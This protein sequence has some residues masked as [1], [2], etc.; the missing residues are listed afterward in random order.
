MSKFK[1]INTGFKAGIVNPMTTTFADDGNT[2]LGQMCTAFYW[3]MTYKAMSQNHIDSVIELIW[4]KDSE[5]NTEMKELAED[6]KFGLAVDI[7]TTYRL[8]TRPATKNTSDIYNWLKQAVEVILGKPTDYPVPDTTIF[9]ITGTDTHTGNYLQILSLI[10]PDFSP[11]KWDLMCKDILE[12]AK[13]RPV[14]GARLVKSRMETVANLLDWCLGNKYNGLKPEYIQDILTNLDS[15]TLAKPPV[16]PDDYTEAIK[17][18]TV[19]PEV[20]EKPS[21][22]PEPSTG[23]ETIQPVPQAPEKKPYLAPDMIEKENPTPTADIPAEPTTP[24]TV[25]PTVQEEPEKKPYVAPTMSERDNPDTGIEQVQPPV[26]PAQE[27]VPEATPIQ[28]QVDDDSEL[29]SLAPPTVEKKPYVAPTMTITEEPKD[30]NDSLTQVD[31]PAQTQETK[32][33]EE[34]KSI[35]TQ[36]NKPNMTKTGKLRPSDRTLAV[37]AKMSINKDQFK[38]AVQEVS[39]S[40]DSDDINAQYLVKFVPGITDEILKDILENRTTKG[41]YRIP[42]TG[43]GGAGIPHT[44]FTG[45]QTYSSSANSHDLGK[46]MM[47]IG[48]TQD[49]SSVMWNEPVIMEMGFPFINFKSP[50]IYTMLKEKDPEKATQAYNKVKKLMKKAGL[51]QPI[52]VLQD[53]RSAKGVPCAINRIS[54]PAE[55]ILNESNNIIQVDVHPRYSKDYSLTV[56]SLPLSKDFIIEMYRILSPATGAKIYMAHLG[57]DEEEYADMI[58]NEGHPPIYIFTP[59]E[60]MRFVKAPAGFIAKLFTSN[61]KPT[62]V[63]AKMGSHM[64]GFVMPFKTT[65]VLFTEI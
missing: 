52:K 32:P 31:T 53:F 29:D 16:L 49:K 22:Q 36:S 21:V 3:Q 12:Y 45:G 62:L 10:D 54:A 41:S 59:K 60:N 63:E 9:S 25:E 58:A 42:D 48:Y 20:D 34:K 61:N 64:G 2:P 38:E 6:R 1:L 55:E 4:T 44:G 5:Q 11:A 33:T 37:L 14:D 65:Q 30:D 24:E 7:L 43:K 17:P 47:P 19:E 39:N 28:Q 35:T 13:N 8:V 57:V 56:G 15:T 18:E 51:S 40:I 26:E 27:T 46:I 50:E 23:P